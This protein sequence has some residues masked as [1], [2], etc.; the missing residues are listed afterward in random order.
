MPKPFN[1]RQNK[2]FINMYY[3]QLNQWEGIPMPLLM[4]F[5]NPE[6][7][8]ETEIEPVIYNPITQIV[9]DCGTRAVGTKCLKRATTGNKDDSKNVIDDTKYV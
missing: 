1:S 7:I 2:I 3:N 6:K 8:Q 9:W 5:M 4:G